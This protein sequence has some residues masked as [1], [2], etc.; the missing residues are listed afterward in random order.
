[1]STEK[2]TR[3]QK[4]T[5]KNREP[6]RRLRDSSQRVQPPA[7]LFIF[8]YFCLKMDE[9]IK[10]KSFVL[11]GHTLVRRTLVACL[12]GISGRITGGLYNLHS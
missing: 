3:K 10:I 11:K 9:I 6:S 12:D 5:E 8:D 4:Q 1:M 2:R 7:Q